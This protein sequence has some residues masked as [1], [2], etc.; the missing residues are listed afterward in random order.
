[1]SRTEDFIVA[2]S[3]ADIDPAQWDDLN[4]DRNPFME[5][6]FLQALED[7]AC[8]GPDT[9]WH[10]RYLLLYQ[11]GRLLGAAASYLREDS[12]G[13]YIFDHGWADAYARSGLAYYPKLAVAAPFTPANGQRLL[14]ARHLSP[15]ESQQLRR[16]LAVGLCEL[17]KAQGCSGVHVLFH[18]AEELEAL[19]LEGYL[20]RFTL[21]FHWHNQGYAEFDDF[22]GA[23]RSSRRKLVRKERESVGRLGLEIRRLQ[24]AQIEEQHMDAMYAFYQH[25]GS[26]KW[27]R[28]YLNRI[29]FRKIL[30][31]QRDRLLLVFAYRDAQPIAGT[32]NFMKD[33]AIFG[34]Y[35]GALQ[36]YPDLHFE[37][38]YY[39][40]IEEAI[41][42]GAALVEAG[43]QGEHKFLRGFGAEI[44]LSSHFLLNAG[45]R[46]A[47]G[48]FLQM[49]QT[50]I[51]RTQLEYNRQSPLKA[52]RAD[53]QLTIAQSTDG[54]AL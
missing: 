29:W 2:E 35:W 20:P 52:L 24:G 31:L 5:Y 3:L 47:I 10:P 43:A 27:G 1:M 7:S 41:A 33:D 34:R 28:P 12:M 14:S 26:R 18:S 23:L 48:R 21:Q 9:G 39:Q 51:E 38:C 8:V 36:D 54:A 19:R 49:E 25:T 17:A 42:K 16:R 40:L 53:A 44:C 13:E 46:E 45:G 22:L 6:G 50:Q 4:L 15:E 32:L 37:L 11:E 30:E